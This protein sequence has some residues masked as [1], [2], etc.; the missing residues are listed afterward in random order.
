MFIITWYHDQIEANFIC[1]YFNL[2]LEGSNEAD[3]QRIAAQEQ[4]QFSYETLSKATDKFHPSRKLGEGGFGP[5]FK[6]SYYFLHFIY[7]F[8]N[9]EYSLRRPII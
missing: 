3:L 5:V 4:K 9:I 8:C 2:V 6:V 7:Y 1:L